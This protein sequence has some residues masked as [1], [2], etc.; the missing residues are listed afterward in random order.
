MNAKYVDYRRKRGRDRLQHLRSVRR[1]A[2]PRAPSM[3]R[4]TVRPNGD[5]NRGFLN[6]APR[7]N[8]L[9]AL[10]STRPAGHQGRPAAVAAAPP[11]GA[12]L[13]VSGFF[14]TTS[15]ALSLLAPQPICV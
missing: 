3:D 5:P 7:H 10:L 2:T 9:D 14:S 12:S 8:A 11:F 13:V 1:E 15:A 6:A 4:E